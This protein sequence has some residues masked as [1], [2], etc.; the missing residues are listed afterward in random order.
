MNPYFFDLGSGHV[1][2]RIRKAAE[3][4]GGRVINYTEPDGRKRHWFEVPNFGE[5]FNSRRAN[6]VREAVRKIS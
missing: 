2:A 5:P 1:P 4:A 6:V 3:N